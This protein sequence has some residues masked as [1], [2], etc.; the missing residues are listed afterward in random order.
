MG[1]R[2][3]F[4]ADQ[5][6]YYGKM[7]RYET[8]ILKRSIS[9]TGELPRRLDVEFDMKPNESE[10]PSRRTFLILRHAGIRISRVCLLVYLGLVALL[11][12]FQTRLIFPGSATQGSPDAKVEP[13]SGTELLALETESKD[14]VVALFGPALTETGTP[15]P[16]A[17]SRPTLLYFYGNGTN[18]LDVDSEVF[19]RFRRMGV[20]VLV[21]D[22]AGYGMSGGSAG[23]RPCYQTADA[24]YEHLMGR[25][26][27]DSNRIVVVGC[28]LGGAVAID[29]AARRA[30]AGLV[31]FSTFT[32]MSEMASRRYPFVPASLLLRHRF[33]SID[34]IARVSCPI[35]LGHGDSDRF[36]PADMSMTLAAAATAPV[37]TF[38]VERADHNDFY[39]VGCGQV[40]HELRTFLA[41]VP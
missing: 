2:P 40:F 13:R 11:Y 36:I 26:D 25:K 5:G 20:N 6:L 28:S 18:L 34:K 38:I 8:C 12:M 10:I 16:E 4:V 9:T 35:L 41:R 7:I 1:L 30:V 32:R 3:N 29:L 24:C 37:T 21:P 14:Q 22:Y 17:S 31:A 39:E 33:D 15:H 23:E 19:D 27:V